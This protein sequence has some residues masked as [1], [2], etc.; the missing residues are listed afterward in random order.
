MTQTAL[1]CGVW[2]STPPP[3]MGSDL[4]PEPHTWPGSSLMLVGI[5]LS[6]QQDLH[7]LLRSSR[8]LTR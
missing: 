3:P 6:P 2:G 1:L 4:L 7:P 8:S 5:S